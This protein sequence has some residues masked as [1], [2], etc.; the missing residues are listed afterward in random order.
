MVF[1]F[2]I[3]EGIFELVGISFR[4]LGC[5]KIRFVRLIISN[6]RLMIRI[7]FIII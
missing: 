4:M 2:G 5:L 7:F 6:L 3:L 1:I